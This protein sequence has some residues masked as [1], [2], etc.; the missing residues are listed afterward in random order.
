[1]RIRA[2][3]IPIAW[4]PVEANALFYASNAVWKAVDRE[5]SWTRISPDLAQQTWEVAATA[6]KYARTVAPA[7]RGTITALL[8]SLSLSPRRLAVLRAGTDDGT[9]QV[10][11]DG[12]ARW[13][14]V[15]PAAIK[16]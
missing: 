6:G 14:N 15:T 7:P 2:R 9:I 5:H 13:K 3:T 1:M 8:I 12:G 10:T 16:P 4:S 11:A